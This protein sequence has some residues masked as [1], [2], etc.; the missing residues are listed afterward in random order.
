MKFKKKKYFFKE[1]ITHNLS[2][3]LKIF[4]FLLIVVSGILGNTLY[5]KIWPDF[6]ETPNNS[7]NIISNI[8]LGAGLNIL[9]TITGF[10]L[11]AGGIFLIYDLICNTI[12]FINKQ[13]AIKRYTYLPLTSDEV[14][15]LINN[16]IIEN[17][18]EAYTEYIFNQLVYKDVFNNINNTIKLTDSDMEKLIQTYEDVFNRPL[19]LNKKLKEYA[20]TQDSIPFR[21]KNAL[22]Y[23]IDLFLNNKTNVV[24]FTTKKIDKRKEQISNRFYIKVNK[25]N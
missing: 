15:S 5:V 24:I 23:N 11:I 1:F 16:S 22:P 21:Y 14:K 18:A 8:F 25:I 2:F 7:S 3:I 13:K 17:K 12:T 19:I 4:V 10:I 20:D 6:F 9:I